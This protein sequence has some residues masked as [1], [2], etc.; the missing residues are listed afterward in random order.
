H[1]LFMNPLAGLKPLTLIVTFQ[2]TQKR[3]C[4]AGEPGKAVL[5]DR[6]SAYGQGSCSARHVKG[7]F[8]SSRCGISF[9]LLGKLDSS[10]QG[11][12]DRPTE[13]DMIS[14]DDKSA[15]RAGV[16]VSLPTLSGRR[17]IIGHSRFPGQT[18]EP[19]DECI[20]NT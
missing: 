15:Q 11:L 10:V 17:C 18:Q 13:P 3:D 1:L 8:S 6:L 14:W 5:C 20:L 7:N 9:S 2:A 4:F 19:K 16:L 12:Q